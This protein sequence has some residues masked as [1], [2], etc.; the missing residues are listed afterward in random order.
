M[1]FLLSLI[2]FAAGVT[3]LTAVAFWAFTSLAGW[4]ARR[5]KN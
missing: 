1:L 5:G 2:I 4:L 3:F